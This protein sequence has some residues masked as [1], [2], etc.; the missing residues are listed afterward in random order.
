M[1]PQAEDHLMTLIPP[2]TG[3]STWWVGTREMLNGLMDGQDGFRVVLEAE[4]GQDK[5]PKAPSCPGICG[6]GYVTRDTACSRTRQQVSP[7]SPPLLVLE[8]VLIH[9]GM[10]LDTQRS[11]TVYLQSAK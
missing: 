10:F 4:K 6:D 7:T 1:V 11:W 2:G 5:A 9:A 3:P 8:F